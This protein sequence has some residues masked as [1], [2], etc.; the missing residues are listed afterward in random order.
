MEQDLRH[1]AAAQVSELLIT[2]RHG[3]I[4]E[5]KDPG[6]WRNCIVWSATWGSSWTHHAWVK[7]HE[8]EAGAPPPYHRY[9]GLPDGAKV[10][11]RQVCPS[12][13]GLLD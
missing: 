4:V 8:R 3:A 9:G 10:S 11:L 6:T 12:R 13:S 5:T 2:D 1:T 7:L